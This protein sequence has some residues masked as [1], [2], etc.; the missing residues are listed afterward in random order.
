[1]AKHTVRVEA[2]VTIIKEFEVDDEGGPLSENIDSITYEFAY[3]SGLETYLTDV[4][5]EFGCDWFYEFT[6]LEKIVTTK[7]VDLCE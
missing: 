5:S 3:D 4:C 1:M 6:V 2:K 7:Y